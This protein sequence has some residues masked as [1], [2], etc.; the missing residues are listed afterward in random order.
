MGTGINGHLGERAFYYLYLFSCIFILLSRESDQC[1]I[2]ARLGVAG[3][4]STTPRWGNPAKC[5]SQRHNK[6]TCRLVLHTVPLMLSVKQGSCEY[7]FFLKSLV[8]PDSESNPSLQLKRQTLHTTRHF[9]AKRH[10]G[11]MSIGTN[12][13]LEKWG[14]WSKWANKQMVARGMEKCVEV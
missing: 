1:A 4:L 7:Q 10:L 5:L 9:G 6:Y 8:W 11:P 13:H 12:K 3:H 2:R 14:V